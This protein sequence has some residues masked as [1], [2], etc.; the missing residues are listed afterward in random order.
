M[1]GAPLA[2]FLRDKDTF[3]LMPECQWKNNI[4]SERLRVN[5]GIH[6]A[7]AQTDMRI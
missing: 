4:H 1:R 5:T 6:C 7:P 3:P 2:F